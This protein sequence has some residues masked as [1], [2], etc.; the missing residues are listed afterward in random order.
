MIRL[1]RRNVLSTMVIAMTVILLACKGGS[2]PAGGGA[3]GGSATIKVGSLASMTGLTSTF[4]QSSDKGVRLAAEE[5]NKAGG[6]L[7]RSV[8]I[9]T[10]DTE[11]SADKTPLAVL[12]LIEQDKVVAVLGEVASSRSIAAA[13]ACQQAG[14]P[15]LSPASTNAK[16][17]KLGNYIFRSC[18]VDDFQGVVIAKFTAED[19]NL[20]K[21][22][23][24][25]DVKNDYST[26]LTT[27]LTD[28]FPKLGGTI[29]AKESYQAGDSSFKTQLIN[30][31]AANP[32]IVFL[33]GYYTEVA[34]ILKDARELGLNCPFIGGDGW[35]S[36][37]TLKNGGK[38]VEGCYFTNHYD[39][40]DPDP[41]VVDFVQK[42][43]TRYDGEVPDAMAVLGYDAAN[44]LF[45]AIDR[46]K[47]TDGP[48]LR[49]SLGKTKDFPAVTGNI[50]IN[51]DRNAI[52]PAVVLTIKDGKFQLV[53]RVNP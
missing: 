52:K 41:R 45:A 13:P 10:A 51:K 4:G 14:I 7:G 27:I 21:A 2:G 20:K 30:I 29:V 38:N 36:D 32:E 12:K 9:D 11:S 28:D 8:E 43:K 35:D 49:D 53:K 44:I 42:F 6:L 48:A 31:K 5:R 18:F 33:P 17:T 50:T 26:G 15:L 22:A 40:S 16:V 39:S 1:S 34:Q 24:L 25:T 19:L 23:I 3:T 37:L 47:S 46:A